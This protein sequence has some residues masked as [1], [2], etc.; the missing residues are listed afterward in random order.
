GQPAVLREV[1]IPQKGDYNAD[2]K[3]ANYEADYG[4][5][6]NG[7]PKE[8]TWHHKEDG[9]TMQLVRKDVHDRALSS[10]SGAAHTGGAS[11]VKDPQ[12]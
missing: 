8:Y 1:E 9:V 6:K 12:F 11:I 2:F 3:A 4:N 10:G 7:H 5:V